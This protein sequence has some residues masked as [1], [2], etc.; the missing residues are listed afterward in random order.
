MGISIFRFFLL[1]LFLCACSQKEDHLKEALEQYHNRDFKSALYNFEKSCLQGKIYSCKMTASIYFDGKAGEK[2]KA[3]SLK[4]LEYAC[5]WGDTSSCDIA[6]RS[7]FAISL[8]PLAHKML[9][10]GCQGGDSKACL[11]LAI[12]SYKEKNLSSSLELASKSCYGGNLKG[13]K[14]YLAIAE[15]HK[16]QTQKIKMIE[17]QIK[18][19][20]G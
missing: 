14:L 7:Y 8:F 1:C 18:K 19:I 11:Q 12:H 4:A 6:Y 16:I 3:K 2:S 17:K 5:K 15:S 10:Y 13:C 20:K 9:E